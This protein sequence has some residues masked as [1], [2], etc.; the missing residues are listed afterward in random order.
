MSVS[1]TWQITWT[2]CDLPDG[3]FEITQD[4]NV[5]EIQSVNH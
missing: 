5:Q 2:G 3:I 4:M 1:V